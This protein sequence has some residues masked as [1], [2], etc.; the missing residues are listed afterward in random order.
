MSKTRNVI[1]AATL[2]GLL[3]VTVLAGAAAKPGDGGEDSAADG[4]RRGG[5]DRGNE[6]A[7]NETG[8]KGPPEGRPAGN[9]SDDKRADDNRSAGR[10]GRAEARQDRHEAMR[11]AHAQW[12]ACR[13]EARNETMNASVQERCMEEKAFFLN[14][15]HARRD[16][17]ALHGGIA[18][19]ERLLGRLEAR[20][21]AL[22][23][24]LE[25][26]N[27]SANETA[28]VQQRLERIEA[29]QERVAAKLEAMRERVAALHERWHTVRDLSRDDAE[30]PADSASASG[31]ASESQTSAAA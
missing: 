15:T 11:E 3:A 13:H 28:S 31:S 12:K 25:S 16:G 27:L 6:T 17:R 10:D 14:A 7:D 29:H 30:A 2:V 21:I 24:R 26:G 8:R 4:R 18:A 20:E 5:P 9:R 19:M 1:L 23:D 22:Q